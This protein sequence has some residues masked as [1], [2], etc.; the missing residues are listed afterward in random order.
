MGGHWYILRGGTISFYV[1]MS[2]LETQSEVL[3]MRS[4]SEDGNFG[5]TPVILNVLNRWGGR[6]G[7]ALLHWGGVFK[8]LV[9]LAEGRKHREKQVL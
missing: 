1:S 7:T 4:L 2:P 9:L 3:L 5:L 6:G 8:G